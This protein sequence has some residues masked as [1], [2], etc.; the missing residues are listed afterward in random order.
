ML[1]RISGVRHA[2]VVAAIG[3][4]TALTGFGVIGAGDHPERFETF[5]VVVAPAGADGL[6]ITETFDHDSR[7]VSI[8]VLTTDHV[9]P[10]VVRSLDDAGIDVLDVVVRRPTLDDVFLQLTGHTATA[11]GDEPDNGDDP[12]PAAPAGATETQGAHR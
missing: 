1:G 2:T 11:E 9:V 4:L 10:R 12:D 8:P 3:S 5:H 6:R 7:T